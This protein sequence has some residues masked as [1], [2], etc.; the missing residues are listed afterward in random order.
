VDRATPAPTPVLAGPRCRP[1]TGT[2]RCRTRGDD[3]ESEPPPEGYKRFEIRMSADGGQATLA[4]PAFGTLT[5]TGAR[6]ACFYFDAPAGTTH[7]VTFTSRP[8]RRE[9]GVTPRLAIAEYGPAGPYWYDVI[10]VACVGADGR[11][12]KAGATAWADRVRQQRRGRQ[13]PCGSVVV[14]GLGWETSGAEDRRDGG[15]LHDFSVAFRFD[16]K[17]FAPQLPP[18]SPECVPK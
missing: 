12:T 1:D 10:S 4:S 3:A 13:D 16:V 2:C 14:S 6:E 11:C 18:N 5:T 9:A 17:R 15:Y 8:E 7:E